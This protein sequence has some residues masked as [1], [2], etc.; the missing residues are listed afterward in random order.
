[1]K[2]TVLGRE[3][4]IPA[5]TIKKIAF[6]AVKEYPREV[7]GAVLYSKT[8]GRWL[9]RPLSNSAPRREQTLSFRVSVEELLALLLLEE[10]ELLSLRAFFHSHPLGEPEL[11]RRDRDSLFWSSSE[12]TLPLWPKVDIIVVALRRPFLAPPGYLT[13]KTYKIAG[14]KT[15][16]RI[17]SDIF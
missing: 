13:V 16:S 3:G 7:V 8:K 6:L 5:K 4:S 2:I 15:N 14:S 9:I 17:D 12:E 11:S 1:M 10:R